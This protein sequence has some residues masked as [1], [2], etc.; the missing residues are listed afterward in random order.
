MALRKA[1]P[2]ER[3]YDFWNILLCYL[4]SQ[5]DTQSQ[6]DRDLFGRLAFMLISK[7]AESVPATKVR[8]SIHVTLLTDSNRKT[9][10]CPERQ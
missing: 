2:K 3:Q 9:Y 10:L 8:L 6:K 7:A 5:D 1:F 4:I